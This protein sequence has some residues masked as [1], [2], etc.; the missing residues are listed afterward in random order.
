MKIAAINRRVYSADALADL[1]A[2]SKDAPQTIELLVIADDYYKTCT[3]TYRGGPR[4]P[5]L[6]RDAAKPD[7]LSEIIQ[8]RARTQ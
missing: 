4:Y 6:V 2:A 3:I 8:S 1:L 5:R 7:N